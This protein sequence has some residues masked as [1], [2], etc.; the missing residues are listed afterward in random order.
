MIYKEGWVREIEGKEEE[1]GPLHRDTWMGDDFPVTDESTQSAV[2]DKAFPL[3]IQGLKELN[4]G[5]NDP[6]IKDCI[7]TTESMREEINNRVRN[8][9]KSADE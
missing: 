5:R 1:K 3:L 6:L 7:E 2:L 4:K 9:V 8:K